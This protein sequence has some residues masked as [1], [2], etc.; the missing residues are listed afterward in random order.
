[1]DISELPKGVYLLQIQTLENTLIT[2]K[3]IK[4]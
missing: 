3:L 2:Q 1:M 4:N